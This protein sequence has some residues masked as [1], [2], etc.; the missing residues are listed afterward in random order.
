M[1]RLLG[2]DLC[3]RLKNLNDHRLHLPVDFPFPP[4]IESIVR[5]DLFLSIIESQ[6]DEL[7][8][9]TAS[10]K[11]GKVTA[12]AV[13]KRFGSVA[14]GDP[15][16]RAGRTLGRLERSIFPGDVLISDDF[17]RQ[18]HRDLSHTESVHS[19]QR[20][21]YQ[22]GIGAKR[23]SR[24]EEMAA[25]SG[26]LTSLTNIV[27]AWNTLKLQGHFNQSLQGTSDISTKGWRQY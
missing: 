27:I 24:S 6:W 13:L 3:P 15:L 26:S 5:P 1:A 23:G 18:L 19:L 20:K 8:R 17:R 12:T 4:S 2:F 9:L 21:I 25:I 22:G 16:Y 11:A 10:I 14:S 7:V